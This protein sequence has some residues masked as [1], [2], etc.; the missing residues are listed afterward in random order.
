MLGFTA[1]AAG[2]FI[3]AKY[4]ALASCKTQIHTHRSPLG[5]E[6]SAVYQAHATLLGLSV[7]GGEEGGVWVG[8]VFVFPVEGKA[9][10]YTALLMYNTDVNN[11]VV[12][13]VYECLFVCKSKYK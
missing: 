13:G 7:C 10:L 4:R 9:Q 1:S 5:V 2:V 12:Y 6:V 3:G 8:D 11:T